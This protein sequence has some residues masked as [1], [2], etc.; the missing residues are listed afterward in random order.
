MPGIS[1][2]GFVEMVLGMEKLK[3]RQR[4]LWKKIEVVVSYKE[5]FDYKK[6]EVMIGY[7]KIFPRSVK[8]QLSI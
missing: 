8:K 5:L 7:Q 6:S 2:G 1:G 4:N 3:K